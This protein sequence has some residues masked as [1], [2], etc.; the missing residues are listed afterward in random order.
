[1]APDADEQW[2]ED[3]RVAEEALR[4]AQ[5]MP[6]GPE[7]IAALNRAG[8]MRFDADLKRNVFTAKRRTNNSVEG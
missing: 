2:E 5:A 8:K 1:M 4:R 3:W 6:A 7:R